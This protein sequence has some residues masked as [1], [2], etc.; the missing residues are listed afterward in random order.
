MPTLEKMVN[1][2]IINPSPEGKR[3]KRVLGIGPR[4]EFTP[5]YQSLDLAWLTGEADESI[6]IKILHESVDRMDYNDDSDLVAISIGFTT[7]ALRAYQIADELRRRGKKVILGGVHVWA[8][9][10]EAKR[11]AD[12]IVVGEAEGIWHKVIEDFQNG[13]LQERYDAPWLD[14]W[15]ISPRRDLID[16]RKFMTVNVV[17]TSRGCPHNCDFCSVTAYQGR[18]MR[19]RPIDDVMKEI[20]S[21]KGRDLLFLDDNIFGDLK[22]AREL[23]KALIPLKKRWFGQAPYYVSGKKDLMELAR[24]SGCKALFI[25]FESIE[26][27]SL[28]QVSK[29]WGHVP[30]YEKYERSIKDFH[31]YGF[32]VIG[33]FI[34][35]F[36]HDDKSVFDRTVDFALKNRIE[37]VNLGILTPL[38]GTRLFRTFEEQGRIISYDW[39]KYDATHVVF[40]PKQMTPE[41][42]QQGLYRAYERF[43]TG[44]SVLSA[45]R[46]PE[47]LLPIKFAFW[48]N[49][50]V[51]NR[52]HRVIDGILQDRQLREF[53]HRWKG[54]AD[55][56]Q[57]YLAGKKEEMHKFV[58]STKEGLVGRLAI[59]YKRIKVPLR[60]ARE[61]FFESA[62]A[63]RIRLLTDAS[64]V[65]QR[66]DL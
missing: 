1:L 63:D 20:E 4:K 28:K 44:R 27:N 46:D 14:E 31:A 49:Y 36:D 53:L 11:H 64:S 60:R 33:S 52:R 59:P 29:D 10:E 26:D 66:Y 54:K 5:G 35:G 58:V 8:R 24:E 45:I 34:F 40:Q 2:T 48:N 38:P 57:Y 22:Y 15:R 30:A 43:Y 56:V 61:K 12:A 50:Q 21:L 65:T 51:I 47:F 32:Y 42:L 7:L 25:G 37:L 39:S 62:F 3:A 9:P 18:E 41:Q 19:H 13:T 23:L 17:Q 16:P 6:I 55:S